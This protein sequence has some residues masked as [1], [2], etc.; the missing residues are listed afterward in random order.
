MATIAGGGAALASAQSAKR[1]NV[2]F[3]LSDEHRYDAMGFLKRATMA[4]NP[5]T[6]PARPRRGAFQERVRYDGTLLSFPKI[7]TSGSLIIGR[8]D[9]K[10]DEQKWQTEAQIIEAVKQVEAGRKAEEV[11]R[12]GRTLRHSATVEPSSGMSEESL[13]IA[14]GK[15]ML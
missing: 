10:T 5:A 11:A 4:R 12:D 9:G 3:I 8:T 7:R 6:G 14:S 13:P 15:Q 1:R 2:I